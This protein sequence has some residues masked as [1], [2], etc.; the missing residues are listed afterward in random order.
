MSERPRK[1]NRPGSSHG[2][3][4]IYDRSPLDPGS[5]PSSSSINRLLPNDATQF[6]DSSSGSELAQG[7]V[8]HDSTDLTRTL[9]GLLHT[10]PEM[11]D[12]ASLESRIPHSDGIAGPVI[13]P[14]DLLAESNRTPQIDDYA[15]S[16]HVVCDQVALAGRVSPD[17]QDRLS[18]PDLSGSG[19]LPTISSSLSDSTIG[20]VAS[21]PLT[22]TA[23]SPGFPDGPSGTTSPAGTSVHR[24]EFAHVFANPLTET[25]TASLGGLG[26]ISQPGGLG[27]ISQSGGLGDISPSTVRAATR[28]SSI[29]TTSVQAPETGSDVARWGYSTTLDS[30]LLPPSPADGAPSEGLPETITVPSPGFANL[31][32]SP[33]DRPLPFPGLPSSRAGQADGDM[34]SMQGISGDVPENGRAGP[35]TSRTDGLLEQILDELRRQRQSG[36]V[37]SHRSVYPER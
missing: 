10:F 12:R 27:D 16:V 30:S 22:S 37:D 31:Q 14:L 29:P 4:S 5:R 2:G 36:F 26:D 1:M 21:F 19:Q 18:G 33:F 17:N 3:S 15:S 25:A 20:T 35:D 8:P 6:V 23:P 9:R 11:R 24:V 7:A 28:A 13:A 32:E 34:Y